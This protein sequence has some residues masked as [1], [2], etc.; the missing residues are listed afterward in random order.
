MSASWGIKWGGL[1]AM[2]GGVLWAAWAILVS[3][4]PEGCIGAECALPGRSS[5]GYSHLAPLLVVAALLIASGLGAA[6]VLARATGRFGRLGRIGLIVG[7]LGAAVLTASVLVQSVFF[8]G[9]FPLM[10]MFVIPGVLA[11]GLGFLLFGVMLLRV[12]PRWAG[13]LLIIG[14]LALLS[15]NDQ[16]ERILLAV[17]FGLAWIAVGYILWSDRHHGRQRLGGW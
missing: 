1:A 15:V 13:I 8:D 17:P 5:R 11:L 12:L 10:P 4:T 7:A 2:L 9:D 3:L 6:V 16:N 14:S